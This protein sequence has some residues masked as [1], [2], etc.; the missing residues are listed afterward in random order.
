MNEKEQAIANEWEKIMDTIN[1]T[2]TFA[3]SFGEGEFETR[4]HAKGAAIE[5]ARKKGLESFEII[6]DNDCVVYQ[7]YPEIKFV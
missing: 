3:V 7:E 5:W 1:G 4:F 2:K 6:D